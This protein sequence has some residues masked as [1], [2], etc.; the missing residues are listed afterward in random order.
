MI[1]LNKREHGKIIKTFQ[2]SQRLFPNKR[3]VITHLGLEL[4][5]QFILSSRHKP[6]MKLR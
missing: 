3:A 1:D 2:H 4:S 5:Y 6:G